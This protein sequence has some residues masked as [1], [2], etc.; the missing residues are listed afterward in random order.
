MIPTKELLRAMRRGA[1]SLKSGA[2]R[3]VATAKEHDPALNVIILEA[4]EA[5]HQDAAIL[6][7]A[8]YRAEE[9]MKEQL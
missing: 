6:E 2:Q 3:M 8:A 5:Q 4:A 1:H 9:E 7:D